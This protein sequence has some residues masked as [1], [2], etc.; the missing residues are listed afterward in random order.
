M[1]KQD[2]AHY[3]NE[4]WRKAKEQEIVDLQANP[5]TL[6]ELKFESDG[7]SWAAEVPE[8][9]RAQNLMVAGADRVIEHFAE[10]D[11]EVT[12]G[13]RTVEPPKGKGPKGA[14]G[15]PLKPIFT[16][17]RIEHDAWGATYLVFGL[18]AI[19]VP[20]WICNVTETVLGEHPKQILVY[21]IEHRNR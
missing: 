20:A 12:M 17:R 8:H 19:P 6:I 10:G 14:D 2:G 7:N 13:F 3:R 21:K 15:Q 18:T 9:T 1:E 16:M 11:N 4:A 5:E